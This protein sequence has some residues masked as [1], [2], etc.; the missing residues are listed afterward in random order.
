MKIDS[1]ARAVSTPPPA[2]SEAGASNKSA[3]AA[4]RAAAV[5][6]PAGRSPKSYDGM[7][8]G[9]NGQVFNPATTSLEDVPSIRPENGQP[10]GTTIFVNG[11]NSKPSG[12]AGQMQQYAN[13][14]GNQV[15]GIYN[16]TEGT[17]KDLLQSVGDKFDLGKNPAVDSLATLVHDQLR[18]GHPVQIAGYSQGGAIVERALADVKNRLM[19]EDGMSKPDAERLMGNLTVETFAGAGSN[20]V[21]GPKYTHYM[22]RADIV[23]NLFGVG[24]PLSHPGRGA[25][26]RTFNTWNPFKAHGWDKY[27]SHWQPPNQNNGLGGGG[28]GGGAW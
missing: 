25:D 16:A 10:K 2:P 28:G 22:N 23:P 7:F 9:A 26:V 3:G 21:D 24:Q 1:A 12:T 19:L 11:I 4:T 14:T 15:V 13:T 8:L 6:E 17:L 20:F 27:M 18:A 5:P